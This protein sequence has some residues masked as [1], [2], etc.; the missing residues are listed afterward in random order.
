M[1]YIDTSVIV[2][3]LDSMD[4]RQKEA[5]ELLNEERDKIVSEIVL[6]ELARI[7]AR[8]DDIT[9]EIARK[10]DLSIEEPVFATILY[11]LRRFNLKYRN[12]EGEIRLPLLG[13]VHKHTATAIESASRV[14][15]KTLDILHV[16]YV[17]LLK[18]EGEHIERLITAERL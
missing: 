18:E 8:R 5:L 16:S 17:K 11:I 13:K 14:K 9:S 1:S 6:A 7:I 2:A 12:I 4:P 15:L 10:L 3:A